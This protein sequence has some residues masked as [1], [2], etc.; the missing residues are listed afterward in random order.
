[1]KW[2]QIGETIA[3]LVFYGFTACVIG[4]G[5]LFIGLCIVGAYL[6][7]QADQK[8]FA[9][10]AQQELLLRSFKKGDFY[11]S[12][13][14]S[15]TFCNRFIS[16]RRISRDEI[17]ITAHASDQSLVPDSLFGSDP[18]ITL[19]PSCSA[20][21]LADYRSDEKMEAA[22]RQE[23]RKAQRFA[24]FF[25]TL[26]KGELFT[27]MDD[28]LGPAYCYE[29]AGIEYPDPSFFIIDTKWQYDGELFSRQISGDEYGFT[30]GCAKGSDRL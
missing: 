21:A 8:A 9:R 28:K 15:T 6:G 4:A 12:T 16:Y 27:E 30:R 20:S 11:T 23:K 10:S 24:A 3:A 22:M 29:F 26:K 13:L 17:D 25:H 19:R 18:S 7:Y 1:L 2:K 14:A 5:A